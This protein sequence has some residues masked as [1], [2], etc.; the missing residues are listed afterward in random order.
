MASGTSPDCTCECLNENSGDHCEIILCKNLG[1][2]D[3]RCE[4]GGDV[5]GTLPNCKCSCKKGFKGDNCETKVDC[6]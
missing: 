1:P 2:H 3:F 5:T 4:N 6:T